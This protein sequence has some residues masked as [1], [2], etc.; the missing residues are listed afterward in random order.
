MRV[1]T[2]Q[3]PNPLLHPISVL[4]VD[5]YEAQR[6]ANVRTLNDAG[7][8]VSGVGSGKEALETA[9]RDRPDVILLD[10]HLPDMLGF[11]VCRQLNAD[12]ETSSIPVLFLTAI[13]TSDWGAEH[14]KSVGGIAYLFNPIEPDTLVTMVQVAS[15]MKTGV[16][17]RE[18]LLL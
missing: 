4:V 11:E 3:P 2:G 13:E 1:A 18:W 9:R 17:P 16:L 6:Y 12:P 10:V 14:A 7:L 5:D 8:N 15:K